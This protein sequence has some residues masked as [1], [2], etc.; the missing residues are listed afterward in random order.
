[1][2]D[3]RHKEWIQSISKEYSEVSRNCDKWNSEKGMF[4]FAGVATALVF[5]TGALFAGNE[6]GQF[7]AAVSGISSLALFIYFYIKNRKFNVVDARRLAIEGLLKEKS[8]QIS[9]DG[10]RVHDGSK[11]LDPLDDASYSP[12]PATP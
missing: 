12:P 8:I 5:C 6:L 4:I 9:P 1:M 2:L 7:V 11:W 3:N 10:R